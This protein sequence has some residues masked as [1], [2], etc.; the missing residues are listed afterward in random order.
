MGFVRSPRSWRPS[1]NITVRAAWSPTSA[2][3]WTG[4]R[5]RAWC[6]MDA[7]PLWLLAELTYRCPLQCPY[8]SNPL[9]FAGPRFKRELSTEEWCRLFREAKGLGV[10]QLGMSGGEPT[11]R[12]DL[13]ELVRTAHELGLYTSLIT[14]AYRL[15]QAR[16]AALRQ[17]GL[18]PVRISTQG[19][20]AERFEEIAR[21]A[22]Y[23][24]QTAASP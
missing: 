13:E 12:S 2:P 8:C 5:R 17:A 1:S 19:A 6:S 9:E 16:L 10:L 11:L 23:P 3:C 14:S 20:D 7:K 4:S 21:T 15:T 22:S 18:H 24:A